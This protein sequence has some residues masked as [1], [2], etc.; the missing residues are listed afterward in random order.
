MDAGFVHK[1]VC[2]PWL[3]RKY[4]ECLAQK[5]GG[6]I[7]IRRGMKVERERGVDCTRL[8]Q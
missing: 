7:N 3:I 5:D 2:I 8:R 6:N 1:T 4:S